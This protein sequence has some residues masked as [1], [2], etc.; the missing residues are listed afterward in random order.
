MGTFKE[1]LGNWIAATHRAETQKR[2]AAQAGQQ[3]ANE[4]RQA[5]KLL[6]EL[7]KHSGSDNGKLE[8]FVTVLANVDGGGNRHFTVRISR[9]LGALPEFRLLEV[10]TLTEPQ[11][12]EEPLP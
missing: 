8:R 7:Q 3:A 12:V 9:S 11:I 6:A 2:L 4:Q 5:E 10:E 1:L